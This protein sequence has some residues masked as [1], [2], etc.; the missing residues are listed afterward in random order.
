MSISLNV[1]S[2]A[3][4]LWAST[5]RRAMVARRLDMRTRSSVRSPAVSGTGAGTATGRGLNAAGVSAG[6]VLDAAA[7]VDGEAGGAAADLSVEA[8]LGAKADSTS[9]RITRPA[10]PVP[11]T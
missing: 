7:D 1:V 3:A 10:S 9:R 5:R 4:V 6:A 8:P 11:W 2:M